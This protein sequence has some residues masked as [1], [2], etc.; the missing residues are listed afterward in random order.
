M[1]NV[2]LVF[3][4]D[5]VFIS[6]LSFPVTWACVSLPNRVEAIPDIDCHDSQRPEFGNSWLASAFARGCACFPAFRRNI[7]EFDR[8]RVE[9]D[10]V[11]LDCAARPCW[12]SC[13]SVVDVSSS[14]R[15]D[16][17]RV[18]LGRKVEVLLFED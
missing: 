7:S 8:P 16:I 5:G 6:R 2:L 4:H 1:R 12:L 14:S 11:L 17:R 10:D 9:V 15:N 18:C 13:N 3:C